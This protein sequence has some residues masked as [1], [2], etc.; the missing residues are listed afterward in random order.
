MGKRG[1]PSLIGRLVAEFV[2]IVIGVLV[3]LARIPTSVGDRFGTESAMSGEEGIY[4]F[5]AAC[6]FD[7]GGRSAES[8]R[9]DLRTEEPQQLM[10]LS[11]HEYLAIQFFGSILEEEAR[12]LERVLIQE[13]SGS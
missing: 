9:R 5:Q 6:E 13:I 2:V 12:P 8:L 11:E 10:R 7:L 1:S 4:G 3:A